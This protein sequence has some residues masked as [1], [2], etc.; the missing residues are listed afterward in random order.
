VYLLVIYK[1]IKRYPQSEE[2]LSLLLDHESYRNIG[3]QGVH[4]K[5]GNRTNY[6]GAGNGG[7]TGKVKVKSSRY[8]PELA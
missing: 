5:K 2:I 3:K 4:G 6:W 1:Q 8:R 7:N